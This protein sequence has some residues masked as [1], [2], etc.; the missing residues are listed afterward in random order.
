MGG[1]C[2]GGAGDRVG[3]GKQLVGN[4]ANAGVEN[5]GIPP[6]TRQCVILSLRAPAARAA[7]RNVDSRRGQAGRRAN[8]ANVHAGGGRQAGVQ[9]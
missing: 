6:P 8:H 4:A 3:E 7:A 9:E 5:V 2:G 1:G